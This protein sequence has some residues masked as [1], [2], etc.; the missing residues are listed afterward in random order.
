LTSGSGAVAG[1]QLRNTG[2]TFTFAADAFT[3]DTYSVS[4][5]G[6]SI[7]SGGGHNPLLYLVSASQAFFLQSNLSV[8]SGFFESQSSGPFSTGSL[9]GTYALGNIDPV[10]SSV[11]AISGIAVFDSGSDGISLTLDGNGSGGPLADQLQS[12]TYSMDGT[13]LALIPSGCSI[14]ATPITC[15]TAFY[16]VSPT[17]AVVMD[18]QSANPQLQTADQ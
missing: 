11:G 16:V 5:E 12:V 17:K 14:T 2:G 7:I 4:A 18:L 1:V 6:R 3:G 8:D 10:N 13:G 15:D 9:A